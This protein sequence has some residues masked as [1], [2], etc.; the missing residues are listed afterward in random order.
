[1]VIEHCQ[2][3]VKMGEVH[4]SKSKFVKLMEKADENYVR[5]EGLPLDEKRLCFDQSVVIPDDKPCSINV[6]NLE[7]SCS[8]VSINRNH[9]GLL[10]F[11][12]FDSSS[13]SDSDSDS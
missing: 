9:F 1:M 10:H 6:A 7:F 11:L 4:L 13:S 5:T 8:S 3:G 12:N 2:R